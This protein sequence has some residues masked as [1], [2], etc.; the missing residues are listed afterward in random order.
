MSDQEYIFE[1]LIY[2]HQGQT[3]ASLSPSKGRWATY[4]C[5][6]KL[7]VWGDKNPFA[8]NWLGIQEC[9]IIKFLLAKRDN[10]KM[11]KPKYNLEQDSSYH[12]KSQHPKSDQVHNHN[13]ELD[14]SSHKDW[15]HLECIH[16]QLHRKIH[17]LVNCKTMKSTMYHLHQN[18]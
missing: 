9:R 4:L 1:I 2:K 11:H 12:E 17:F 10:L 8:W 3:L 16:H 7:Q 5:W 18:R 13:K 6:Q 14:C 15:N